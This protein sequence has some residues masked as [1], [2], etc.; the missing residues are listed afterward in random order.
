MARCPPRRRGAGRG[1][2]ERGL[3]P[4]GGA[5]VCGVGGVT[6]RPRDPGGGASSHRVLLPGAQS[7]LLARGGGGL[8]SRSPGAIRRRPGAG[9]GGCRLCAGEPRRADQVGPGGAAGGPSAGAGVLA[10]AGWRTGGHADPPEERPALGRARETDG[11]ASRWPLS[12]LACHGP[13]RSVRPSR[14]LGAIAAGGLGQ[15]QKLSSAGGYLV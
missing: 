12:K 4:A 3:R 2:G 15:R 1:E 6:G 8:G 10:A 11:S 7:R 13:V 14:S 9:P 5:R